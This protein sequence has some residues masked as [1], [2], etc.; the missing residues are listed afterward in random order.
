M[1]DG[2]A[3]HPEP[4]IQLGIL[5]LVPQAE[6]A[7]AEQAVREAARLAQTAEACGYTRYWAAEHHDLPGLA[8][9]APEV[10]LAH[11]GAVTRSIKLGT[12][13]LL[14]PHYSP[15][16]VAETF[17]LLSALYPGRIE[18]GIGRA[19]GGPAHASMA[20][21]G[22]F[23]QRVYGMEQSVKA[24]TGLLDGTYTYEGEPVQAK[25]AAAASP[26]LWMLGT[27]SRSA[28]YAAQSGCGFVFGAFMSDED[29][30]AAL[31]AY[32]QAFV[33]SSR[34]PG[35]RTILAV[36]V[37][38]AESAGEAAELARAGRPGLSDEAAPPR[39]QHEILGTAGEAVSRLRDWQS[40]YRNDEFL[41]MTPSWNYEARQRSVRLLAE[42]V[43]ALS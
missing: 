25:P 37:L 15:L 28:G 20:L 17:N 31:A 5:D 9:A 3:Y 11:I 16:K 27:G 7:A 1:T 8:C 22:N 18:L 6:G 12:G 36:S 2:S 43:K 35:P 42:C 29:P 39:R 40:R 33:P 4:P 23:L 21:S 38:C 41:I 30:A 13:A 32:R 14:L 24:L 34:L 26:A 10:L 19:P